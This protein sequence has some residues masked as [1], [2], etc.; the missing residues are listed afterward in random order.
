MHE[1][2]RNTCILLFT[3]SISGIILRF[4]NY[5]PHPTP[6][7]RSR[8]CGALLFWRLRTHRSTWLIKLENNNGDLDQLSWKWHAKIIAEKFTLTAFL[9][10]TSKWFLR[11]WYLKKCERFYTCSM[12]RIMGVHR[13]VFK[14]SVIRYIISFAT[15][16][17]FVVFTGIQNWRQYSQLYHWNSVE[18]EIQIL[19]SGWQILEYQ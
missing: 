6:F 8:G 19:H 12:L 16:E 18:C 15:P 3:I 7:V 17:P 11:A 13:S 5:T 9:D 14:D 2:F 1:G 4:R 10:V